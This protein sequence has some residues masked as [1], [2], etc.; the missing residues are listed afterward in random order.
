MIGMISR[1]MCI[2]I[3]PNIHCNCQ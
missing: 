1:N 3:W 2:F